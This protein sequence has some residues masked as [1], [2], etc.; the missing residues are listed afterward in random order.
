LLLT[1][2]VME[3]FFTMALERMLTNFQQRSAPSYLIQILRW[4]KTASLC[5][6]KINC[7]ISFGVPTKRQGIVR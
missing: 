3:E 5:P 6:F 7:R 1:P 4:I 2:P